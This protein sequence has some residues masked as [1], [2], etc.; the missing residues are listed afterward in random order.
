MKIHI[1][2]VSVVFT[3]LI[4]LLLVGC[5][6]QPQKIETSEYPQIELK[7]ENIEE[8]RNKLIS[9]MSKA[10]FSLSSSSDS[11]L[12]FRKQLK[13]WEA[14]FFGSLLQTEVNFKGIDC[15]FNTVNGT[16]TI[17]GKPYLLFKTYTNKDAKRDMH[18]N[19]S[20]YNEAQTFLN[21]SK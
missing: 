1:N 2:K 19:A 4:S 18:D 17:K 14:K 21:S 6:K 5:S 13:P 16:T 15:T 11:L 3:I 12:E 8:V 20:Y 7:V 10:D 9:E